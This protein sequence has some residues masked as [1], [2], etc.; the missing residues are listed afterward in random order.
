[1]SQSE[2]QTSLKNKVY[3][4]NNWKQIINLAGGTGKSKL[5]VPAQVILGLLLNDL[6]LEK[7]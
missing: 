1:M 7:K 5:N 2:H 3:V 6:F 4:N